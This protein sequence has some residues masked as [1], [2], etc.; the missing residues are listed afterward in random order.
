VWQPTPVGRRSRFRSLLARRG[1]TVRCTVTLITMG[2]ELTIYGDAGKPA[3]PLGTR[4]RVCAH[5]ASRLRGMKLAPEPQ[6][7]AQHMRAK[8]K[9]A[10][11]T[12]HPKLE[13]CYETPGLTIEFS[14]I[15]DEVVSDISANVR[16]N[17][18]PLPT[19]RSLCAGTPWVV[20]E[21]ASGKDIL[22]AAA[23]SGGWTRFKRWRDWCISALSER[24]NPNAERTNRMQRTTRWRC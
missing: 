24:E 13:G 14:W 1:C 8:L 5:F 17:G 7:F 10:G 20:V 4:E 19:L 23:P 12:Y 21:D 11:L 6:A 22:G 3:R 16:G 9:E 15:D 18:D 2:W